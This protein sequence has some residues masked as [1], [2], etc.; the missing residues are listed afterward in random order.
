MTD[1][2]ARLLRP[3][4]P[5]VSDPWLTI[6][7]AAAETKLSPGTLTRA[8]KAKRLRTV[9]VNNARHYRLRRSWLNDW[10]ESGGE[11]RGEPPT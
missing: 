6:R 5:P 11:G 1:R 7:E 2:L 10:L 9:K 4:P 8:A 3:L